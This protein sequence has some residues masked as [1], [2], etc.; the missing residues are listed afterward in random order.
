ME[1]VLVCAPWFRGGLLDGDVL[2]CCVGEEITSACETFVESGDAPGCD[3]FD[4]GLETVTGEFETDLVVAFACASVRDVAAIDDWC[5]ELKSRVEDLLAL[6]LL[7]DFHHAASDNRASERGAE[8]IYVLVDAVGLDGR[9]DEFSDELFFEIEDDKLL[10]A[11][12]ECF[13]VGSFKVL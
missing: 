8:E 2:L 4:C 7:S 5:R 10:C 3:D 11:N 6:F 9:V 1:E 13:L 12:F